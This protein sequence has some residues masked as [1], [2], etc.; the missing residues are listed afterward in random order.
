M[1]WDSLP[2]VGV[3]Q[4]LSYLCAQVLDLTQQQRCFG[5]KIPGKTVQPAQGEVHRDQCLMLLAL[6]QVS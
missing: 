3:E 4:R 6:Y 1:D 2:M 5:L